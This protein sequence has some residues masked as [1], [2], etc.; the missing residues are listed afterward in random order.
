MNSLMRIQV[1][2]VNEA[3]REAKQVQKDIRGIGAAWDKARATGG[4]FTEFLR[5]NHLE[6]YGKNLQWTGRQLS[7]NFTIPLAAAGAAATKWALANEKAMTQVRKVYGDLN[8]AMQATYKKEIPQLERAFTQLSNVFGVH[9]EEVIGIGAAW[10]AAGSSG[11]ALARQTRATLEAMI[12][13]EMEAAEATKALISIQAQYG[14]SSKELAST[15]AM[16]NV[17][18][19]ETATSMQ[20]LVLG[21]QRAA[22]S[23]R[24]AGV[25]ARHLAAMISA[26]VPAA[27]TAEQAGTA[28]KTIFSRLLAPTSDI[29]DVLGLMGINASSAGWQ[30]LTASERLYK[31]AESSEK[32]TASQKAVVSSVISSRW[33]ITKFDVL[34]RQIASSTGY[35]QRALDAT[36]D[37]QANMTT[38]TRELG[39]YLSSSP[40]AFSILWNQLRNA[41]AEVIVPLI[42]AILG[43]TQRIVDLVH[44]FTSLSPGTQ[45]LILVGLAALAALGPLIQYAG[46]AILLVSKLKGAFVLLGEVGLLAF[47]VLAVVGA[48][49]LTLVRTP[50]TKIANGFSAIGG[51]IG[52]MLSVAGTMF[53]SIG[54]VLLPIVTSFALSVANIFRFFIFSA[55]SALPGIVAASA[56]ATSGIWTGLTSFMSFAWAGLHSWMQ[57]VSWTF[58]QAMPLVSNAISVVWTSLSLFMGRMWAI[59]HGGMQLTSL[60]FQRFFATVVATLPL[61]WTAPLSAMTALWS[62]A[63][64]LMQELW[65]IFRLVWATSAASMSALWATVTWGFTTILSAVSAALVGIWSSFQFVFATI[66]SALPVIVRAAGTAIVLLWQATTAAMVALWA[67]LPAIASAVGT[68]L[69]VAF[70]GPWGW[71]AL[72]VVAFVVA[73]RK[74][75]GGAIRWVM[76]NWRQIPE[77]I[78]GSLRN[79]ESNLTGF[80]KVVLGVFISVLRIIKEAALQVYEWLSY[81]N[82]F[83]R[84]SPSLVENVTAGVEL[85]SR[86]YASLSGIG[87]NFRRAIGDMKAFGVA[88]AAAVA[89]SRA[90]ERSDMRANVVA[91]APGAGGA[92]DALGASVDRLYGDLALVGAQY[93]K[94][95]AATAK[96]K[97]KLD[98][99]NAAL[100]VQSATLALLN[101]E[102]DKYAKVVDAAQSKIDKFASAPLA[103]MR[104]MGDA[105]FANEMAQ[106]RLQ[107][108]MMDW[109]DVNGPLQDA[110]SRLA[111]I[112]GDI[113]KL[114]SESTDLRLAGAGSDITGPI[115]DQIAAL[116]AQSAA[117]QQSSAPMRDM[118]TELEKLQRE[119][120]RLDLMNSIKFDPLEREISQLVQGMNEMPFDAV[121][122][123]IRSQQQIIDAVTP[124]FDR[125]TAAQARQQTVVDALTAAR[126]RLQ[127]GYDLE[128]SKLDS[129]G[130]TY[131]AIEQQIRDM[132]QAMSDFA[133]M[134]EQAAQKMK[135]A[136]DT[137]GSAAQSFMNAG[138]GDFEIPGGLGQLTR[139]EGDISA[140]ADQWAQEAKTQFG[141]FDIFAGL[142]DSWNKA[143]QWILDRIPESAKSWGNSLLT[144][145]QEGRPREMWNSLF[146]ETSVSGSLDGIKS[147]LGEFGS[148]LQSSPIASGISSVVGALQDIW[149]YI[150]PDLID[151]FN[152]VKDFLVD[153]GSAIGDELKNWAPLFDQAKEAIGHILNVL[154]LL[155]RVAI[156]IIIGIWKAAWPILKNVLKPVFDAIV[157]IVKA[158]FQILRGVI[159]FVLSIINGDWGKAWEAI[160]TVVDG[161]WDAIYSVIKGGVGVVI[162]VIRGFV[163]GVIGFFT[164]LWDVLV[165]HSIV[166]DMINAIIEVF[167]WLIGPIKIVFNAI[168]WI[169]ENVVVPVFN[170]LVDVITLVFKG[171]VAVISWA[172]ENVIKPLWT[173]IKWYITNVL[174]PIFNFLWGVI[175]AVFTAIGAAIKWAWENVIRPIWDR[176][177]GF[178]KDTLAPAFGTFRA[179]VST[180][181]DKI[182]SAI[183]VAWDKIKPVFEAIKNFVSDKLLPIWDKLKDGIIGAFDGVKNA[184]GGIWDKIKSTLKT[185]INGVISLVNTLI[186]GMNK[187]VSYIPGVNFTI[188]RIP[189]LR[190]SG[191]TIG[192]KGGPP[193]FA[194]GTAH[195]PHRKV[196]GGFKTQGARAIVGEGRVGYPEYVIP[197]D[198]RYRG[199]AMSLVASMLKDLSTSGKSFMP[200][201]VHPEAF[202]WGGLPSPGDAWNAVKGAA[203]SAAKWGK[204]KVIET[205]YRPI[206]NIADNAIGA[207]KFQFLREIAKGIKG[208]VDDWV[209]G[210]NDEIAA[211]SAAMTDINGPSLKHNAGVNMGLNADFLQRYA[212]YND[213]LGNPFTIV[214]GLRTRAQQVALYNAYL[215]G[216][217]NLAAKP[218]TSRHESGYA[219]D[220]AP[221]TNFAVRFMDAAKKQGLHYPVRSPQAEDWHVEPIVRAAAGNILNL[222]R[223]G[224]FIAKPKPGGHL[225][226]VGEGGES[227]RVTVEPLSKV[228]ASG[229]TYN[230]YGDLEFPNITDPEDAKKF[231]DNLRDLAGGN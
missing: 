105:I 70:S 153:L 142:K 20:D 200:T 117:L 71:A 157:G 78:A 37:S 185:A 33:N 60:A 11:I 180:V 8:P 73:F 143:K 19:N 9:K 223:G 17:V 12:I 171:I 221:G 30:S 218:G 188:G 93:A 98:A 162:G 220:H 195:L 217:G 44:A 164:W 67:G 24:S 50:F 102:V 155:F 85:I 94:Q 181:W 202:G 99:A 22:G 4:A 184:I 145:W 173:A 174:V 62:A 140:L 151:A 130:E 52:S 134:G 189:V 141:S 159:S 197:T 206:S 26:I 48:N 87:K 190:E 81:I 41:M 149:K 86:K 122:A 211:K 191:G 10:A 214:S 29:A 167:G 230:F 126:D 131:D 187:V 175:K 172:W 165:G 106:K 150:G 55:V 109:E 118:Q 120:T 193:G 182:K 154:G 42:P 229:G 5:G 66:T 128:K 75:I 23:A 27:G 192:G 84:H 95:E 92:F 160:C 158:A 207:I 129:L 7:F 178:L 76:S 110:D 59:A 148:W 231:L 3:S 225:I 15:L 83:A 43:A 176:I 210:V 166:P 186:D 196:N 226:R 53:S 201:A 115:A 89:N 213:S 72:A 32:L 34:M 212:Q 125:V 168:G 169:I 209:Y 204:D 47:K 90:T 144:A 112:A 161:I 82:P 199:R 1:R 77:T 28:L 138:A 111:A 46:A 152:L 116:E 216:T 18:E 219:L 49:L 119:G 91:V 127:I 222:A 183:S 147:K 97:V 35:Y 205:I 58:A 163:E 64:G 194:Q 45:Q 203:G 36:A 104:A 38:Y 121:I 156:G 208:K 88:T 74:Q 136:S 133:T 139:E 146:D 51:A 79:L 56:S 13:G 108:A 135:S 170:F 224:Q 101:L 137:L 114:R 179:T 69:T 107:L 40:Q 198:P 2:I 100:E 16:L 123:G 124:A 21:F 68:A 132:E 14:L 80:P 65:A 177:K 25:D 54:R 31:L 61:L 228:S 103:G 227:E 96:W 57:V 63:L 39:I 6:K 215:N 113:E